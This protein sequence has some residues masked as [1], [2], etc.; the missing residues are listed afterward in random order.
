MQV[1][2]IHFDREDQKRYL[3][4]LS[5]ISE[6]GAIDELGVGR[7]R[8]YYSDLMFPGVSSLHQ[9]AK[10]FALMPLLFKE[11]VKKRYSRLEDVRPAIREMEIE[12][13]KRLMKGS[14]DIPG[15]TGSDA[16][17]NGTFVK[18]DPMYIYGMALRTWGIVKTENI[19]GAIFYA[20]KKYHERPVKLSATDDEQGD[21][22]DVESYLEFLS[23][24]VD[25]GYNWLEECSLALTHNEAKHVIDHFLS[26]EDYR[27]TLLHYILDE[28]LELPNI[29]F[30]VFVNLYKDRLPKKLLEIAER[31]C[32][33]SD[34]VDGLFYRY[35]WLYSDRTDEEMRDRFDHWVSSVF[36]ENAQSMLDAISN[37]H[38][39]DNGSIPFC[40]NA[41]SLISRQDWDALDMLIIKR[42]R[43]IK[44]G[45][46][47]KI[48]N[49]ANYQYDPSNPI[50]NYKVE[51]R[52]P[53]VC[54][55][56][57]E[58]LGG[59]RNG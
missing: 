54:T 37:I 5:K 23:L 34:L 16:V 12:L 53:T 50:H 41:I 46:R 36:Q 31:A 2:F 55:L 4:V 18:Y 56:V 26:A 43:A 59:L 40:Q 44:Q 17:M 58:L 47:H 35:N 48:D 51:F 15:I 25:I 45:G 3:A 10:Y 52:W 49:K 20:S 6:G 7:I 57:N 27:E 28:K 32:H 33:F 42:E 8:D 19:E 30:V 9:H 14:P 21:S 24:P 22:D 11:A 39:N 38:I 1:G 13:T 29:E